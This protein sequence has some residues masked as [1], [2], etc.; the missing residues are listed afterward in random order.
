MLKKTVLLASAL[1][2]LAISA[3]Q[4]MAQSQNSYWSFDGRNS[5]GS[6]QACEEARRT[7]TLGGA[8]LGG[9]LGA[10]VGAMAGGDDTRNAVV[11]AVVG[12]VAGGIIGREQVKCTQ[13]AYS[14]AYSNQQTNYRHDGYVATTNNNG[15]YGGSTY[16]GTQYGNSTYYGENNGYYSTQPTRTYQTTQ[17]TTYIGQSGYVTAR[18]G[19]TSTQPVRTYSNSGYSSYGYQTSQPTRVYTTTTRSSGYYPNQPSYQTQRVYQSQPTY[20]HGR[21]S[22]HTYPAT[23]YQQPRPTN[24]TYWSY[25]GRTQYSSWEECQRAS[26]NRT[27]TSGALGAVAGAGLGT[28]AGGDDGRNAVIGAI[29]GGALGAY[30]GNRSIQCQQYTTNYRR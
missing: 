21:P 14:S 10:G 11:G 3:P 5:Y 25:D 4:S 16:G 27:L 7:R 20:S 15:Y 9:A 18:P 19:Y 24:T 1:A 13:Y 8:A 17:P 6:Y 28:A 23:T 22:Y 12:G 26:R 2:G 29:A 30:A